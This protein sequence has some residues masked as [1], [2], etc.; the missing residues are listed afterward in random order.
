MSIWKSNFSKPKLSD[1]DV[2]TK[3]TLFF[4]SMTEKLDNKITKY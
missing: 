3:K 1:E 4:C 2:T